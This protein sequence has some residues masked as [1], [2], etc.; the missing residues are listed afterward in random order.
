ME[1]ETYLK[2]LALITSSFRVSP[3]ERNINIWYVG[4][5]DLDDEDF[6]AAVVTI[7]RTCESLPGENL[8]AVIRN[9]IEKSKGMAPEEA[10][11]QVVRHF[12][13]TGRY[14]EPRFDDP[15]AAEAVNLIGWK[16]LCDTRTSEMGTARAHFYRS[17]AA[18]LKRQQINRTVKL[19]ENA[20]IRSLLSGIGKTMLPANMT[21][22]PK[23][24]IR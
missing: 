12:G 11:G 3:G 18:C 13:I 22:S 10:W 19:L 15:A 7:C 14:G 23:K 9:E 5:Q 24:E 4:L 2:G 8:V 21:S 6:I 1:W 17:Y 20:E 16:N